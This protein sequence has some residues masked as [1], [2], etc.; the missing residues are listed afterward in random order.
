MKDGESI[1]VT[2][3]EQWRRW[4]QDNHTRSTGIWL[5]AYKKAAGDRHVGYEPIIEEALCFGWID[6]PARALDDLRG[7]L[8][9]SPRKPGSGWSR[10]NK[11]RIDRLIAG[12]R[13]Q[14]AGLAKIEAAK[15]DGSW[16]KLDAVEN[17]E[18]PP[19]LSQAFRRH[20]GAKACFEAFPRSAKRAILEWIAHAK[21]P[22]TR[23]ARLEETAR[24]A[25]RNE[26]ANE[27][28]PKAARTSPSSG[29]AKTRSAAARPPRKKPS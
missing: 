29:P 6:G 7:K 21:K 24:C 28:K 11:L 4:L 5:V 17:L 13:M 23:A 8:W 15:A 2:S 20:A 16:S 14:P 26:R 25:A 19:D 18:I 12:G 22:E 10:P 1:E 9:F 27:W 3:R